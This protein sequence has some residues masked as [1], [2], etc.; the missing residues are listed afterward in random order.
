[1]VRHPHCLSSMSRMTHEGAKDWRVSTVAS[2][3]QRYT[4]YDDK[5][6]RGDSNALRL[7]L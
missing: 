4:I 1:M 7:S 6:H 3:R 5:D 2:E